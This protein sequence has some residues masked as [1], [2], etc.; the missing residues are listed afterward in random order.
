MRVTS[1]FVIKLMKLSEA[2]CFLVHTHLSKIYKNIGHKA[3]QLNRAKLHGKLTR[4]KLN[5]E[6]KDLKKSTKL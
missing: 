2:P 4:R 3:A 1:V 5:L 6:F